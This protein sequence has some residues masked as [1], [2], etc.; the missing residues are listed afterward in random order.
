[1]PC[2]LW[3]NEKK[4]NIVRL[5]LNGLGHISNN[6]RLYA[7]SYECTG[8]HMSVQYTVNAFSVEKVAN[9]TFLFFFLSSARNAIGK[10]IIFVFTRIEMILVSRIRYTSRQ[11]S[12]GYDVAES[13]KCSMFARL[14]YKS[15]FLFVI[16]LHGFI[17]FGFTLYF[18][19][20]YKQR[21]R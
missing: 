12:L 6:K 21:L 13:G 19:S 2:G 11:C 10:S 18:Y 4:K 8:T 1:M 16:Q 3:N 15:V 7:T 5:K 9:Y 17:Y 20:E 14:T